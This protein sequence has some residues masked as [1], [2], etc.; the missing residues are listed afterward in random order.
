MLKLVGTLLVLLLAFGAVL[1]VSTAWQG[2]A[3]PAAA[4]EPMI[5][6]MVYFALK[7]N[8]PEAV[9]K[10]VAACRKY[11]KGHDGEVFFA[12]GPRAKEFTR[13]VNDQDW[14]VALHI[15]FK[16]KADHDKYQEHPRH[17]QFI[18]E[19]RENWKKVRVFDSACEPGQ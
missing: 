4:A 1:A 15:V 9:Q 18:S 11:L 13:E 10:M 17:V 2:E 5:G 8:S 6:H 14:D 3:A 7:D 12:A 16:S 19:N